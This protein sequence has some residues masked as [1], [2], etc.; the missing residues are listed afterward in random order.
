MA[1][2]SDVQLQVHESLRDN[3][4]KNFSDAKLSAGG[5]PNSSQAQVSN[6]PKF[7]PS[8]DPYIHMTQ[9]AAASG[10]KRPERL[11]FDLTLLFK[12]GQEL[13][14]QEARARSLGL[15]GKKWGPPPGSEQSSMG[16]PELTSAKNGSSSKNTTNRMNM[17]MNITSSF[18]KMGGGAEPTVTINTKEALRDVFGMYNSPERSHKVVRLNDGKMSGPSEGAML[19]PPPPIGSKHAPVRKVEPMTPAQSQPLSR[20]NTERDI[21][22]DENANIKSG[23]VFL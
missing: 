8:S 22:E 4:L 7:I 3:P 10:S 12:D 20:R 1:V 17:T 21:F 19:P 11:R 23:K 5:V 15:L 2:L 16:P 14:I 18:N 6:G 9:P 13:C